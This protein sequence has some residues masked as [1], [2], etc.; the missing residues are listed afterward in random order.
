MVSNGQE[1]LRCRFVKPMFEEV[2]HAA[3]GYTDTLARAQ[4]QRRLDMLDREI[5]LT[6]KYPEHAAHMPA[7]G[8]ARV[9]RHR[10][11]DQADHG[12]DVLAE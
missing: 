6:G 9:E 3:W 8:E 12:A 1:Q 4:A 10:T 7:T 11:V 2:G 5:V